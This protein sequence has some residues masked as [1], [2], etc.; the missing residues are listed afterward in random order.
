MVDGARAATPPVAPPTIPRRRY[1]LRKTDQ[2]GRTLRCHTLDKEAQMRP[3]S[4]CSNMTEL[5]AEIDD[6]DRQLVALLVTRASYI[7][8]AVELKS[9][10]G[11]QARIDARVDEV[12]GNVR[13]RAEEQGLDPDLAEALWTRIIE[14]S[15]AREERVLGPSVERKT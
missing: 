15:I 3:A 14:W 8:R 13:R 9:A 1:A 2:S 6:L 11:L 7:D 10:V 12:L 5:R 4:D